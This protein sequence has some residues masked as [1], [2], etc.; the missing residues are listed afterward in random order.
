MTSR[1]LIRFAS[2]CAISL[3]I[4][5]AAFGEQ[6][7][8]STFPN[9]GGDLSSQLDWGDVALPGTSDHVK[10]N[11]SGTYT[12]SDNLSIASVSLAAEDVVFDFRDGNHVLTLN[13]MCEGWGNV[14]SL[15]QYHH[16]GTHPTVLLR[17]GVWK[18]ASS[19][20]NFLFVP[21]GLGMANHYKQT[22]LFV[23]TDN[24][25]ITNVAKFATSCR[26]SNTR[27]VVKDGGRLYG[28]SMYLYEN[29]GTNNVLEIG[30]NGVVTLSSAFYS[31]DA[32]ASYRV[33]D[34]VDI[35]GAGASLVVKSSGSGAYV[36]RKSSGMGMYVRDGGTLNTPYL[37]VAG[38]QDYAG[39]S[40][41]WVEVRDGGVLT[42]KKIRFYGSGNTLLVSDA[43]C[44]VTD[45]AS[46]MFS[47]GVAE[48]HGNAVRISG[49][50]SM[51]SVKPSYNNDVFGRYG[52]HNEFVLSDGAT[53][54]PK[55]ATM[56]MFYGSNNT[57]RVSG[58]GTLFDNST[59][60]T[61]ATY[62]ATKIGPADL[63]SD[64]L[65]PNSRDNVIEIMDGAEF[66]VNW[67]FVHGFN[68]K[69]VVSNATLTA[70]S[71][72]ADGVEAYSVWLGRKNSSNVTL[73]VQGTTPKIRSLHS[74]DASRPLRLQNASC[75]RYEIPREGYA[76]GY[77]P[78]ELAHIDVVSSNSR[79][80]I[81]CDNW[82]ARRDRD[83]REIVLFRGTATLS[84]K[85]NAEDWFAAQNLNLPQ[86][87]TCF[88]RGKELILSRK[89]VNG[90]CISLR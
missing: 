15:F 40:N 88:M 62:Y 72:P 12:L 66:R 85:G 68:N 89:V 75:L 57:F 29:A 21:L 8:F 60:A 30:E 24:C 58:A 47:M 16:G 74:G 5:K 32:A 38:Y 61:D 17:G 42:A 1:I 63:D 82:A 11:Q 49:T 37:Y 3:A 87:V 26:A 53:W 10:I 44:R 55:A 34:V 41:N 20:Y 33:N 22:H 19:S 56:M 27:T 71:Y 83:G 90:T 84:S 67:L 69:I 81:S 86:N 65:L 73:V 14:K 46:D 18:S 70:G 7:V 52:H 36:G 28:K 80:E 25:A 4:C 79:L 48:A 31:D 23:V 77:A 59:N 13:A 39:S 76:P 54:A 78:I 50:S 9:A 2:A 6:T 35:H 51:F 43:T 64:A 45:D